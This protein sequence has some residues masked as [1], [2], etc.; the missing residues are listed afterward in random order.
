MSQTSSPLR[1]TVTVA[2]AGLAVAVSAAGCGGDVS[3]DSPRVAGGNREVGKRVIQKY[4]CGSCH[5]I[6]G[7]QGADALVGPPLIHYSQR[8][9][10]AGR[11]A[12]TADN[13]ARWVADPKSVDPE[14]AMPDLGVTPEEA[15]HVAA[16]LQSLK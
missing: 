7:V 12:N 6:P 2:A 9:F 1:R 4:G 10:V 15:R 16:Y 14:T 8:T 11:L 5:T 3:R 13:L